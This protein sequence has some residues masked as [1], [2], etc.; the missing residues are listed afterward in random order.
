M[1]TLSSKA[2]EGKS[3]KSISKDSGG[4]KRAVRRSSTFDTGGRLSGDFGGRCD[5][6][7]LFKRIQ[8]RIARDEAEES[9]VVLFD[10]LDREA[11][12]I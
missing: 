8:N 12:K 2:T 5:R 9:W 1:P 3:S 10:L 6:R 7:L 11:E 4:D